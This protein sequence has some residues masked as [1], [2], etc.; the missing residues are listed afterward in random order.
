M[1][2]LIAVCGIMLLIAVAYSCKKSATVSGGSVYLDLPSTP[3]PY[4]DSFAFFQPDSMNRKA[5]LGR[6][7]FYDTHLSLNNAIS[8]ASCHKQ[9]YSFADNVPF[10]V[11]YEGR[12]TK[13]NAPAVMNVQGRE[14]FFWDGRE[15]NINNLSVRP[16]SNHVEMGIT[17]P[18]TL[19]QKLAA[20]PYYSSL[21]LSA[22]G[23]GQITIDRISDAISLFMQAINTAPTRLDAYV[24][25]DSSAL[26]AQE[27][28]GKA[29]FDSK[30]NCANCHSGNGHGGMF[31][32]FYGGGGGASFLDIGLDNNYVDLGKGEITG[33]ATDNGTFNVPSL[34]NVA[35]TAPYMHDGR[36][37]TLSDVIDHYSHGIIKTPN[38]DPLLIDNSG[39][40]LQMNIPD[41]D[42]Q[43]IIAFLN[44]LTDYQLTTA[45]RFSNPFKLN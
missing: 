27:V 34:R 15:R 25:G 1:K 22:Y 45:P 20:L 18:S 40:A 4:Y 19:P 8:C 6:V 36:Y 11:G 9:E 44:T 23:D 37:K 7:L 31:T 12:L 39:N 10:S 41:Q 32:N 35:L 24:G 21:F 14:S 17:D 28:A 33:V 2:K 30:Y 42:K 3:Y 29:L 16:I 43:A 26:T 5:T 38:L 13:R